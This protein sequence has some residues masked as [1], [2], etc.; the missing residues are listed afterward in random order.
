MQLNVM[1]EGYVDLYAHE[2]NSRYYLVV[3]SSSQEINKPDTEVL[4][5]IE[6]NEVL[7]FN[8]AG[9]VEAVK[10]DGREYNSVWVNPLANKV[11]L[12]DGNGYGPFLSF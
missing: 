12:E 4:G 1:R 5:T 3:P 7:S 11:I 9:E 6:V 2:D 8:P 10:L